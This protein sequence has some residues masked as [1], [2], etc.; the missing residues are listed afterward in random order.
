MFVA[1]WGMDNVSA[2]VTGQFEGAYGSAF[3][4]LT[5]RYFGRAVDLGLRA[6][7]S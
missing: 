4:P 5:D 1:G 7:A 2:G 6:A 3:Y